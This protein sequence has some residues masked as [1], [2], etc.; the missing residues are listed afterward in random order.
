MT[1]R[2]RKVRKLEIKFSKRRGSCGRPERFFSEEDKEAIRK[3]H[4]DLSVNH[5]ERIKIIGQMIGMKSERTIRKI[6]KRHQIIENPDTMVSEEYKEAKERKFKK[7]GKRFFVTWAQNNTPVHKQFLDNIKAYSKKIGAEIHVVLG[8]YKNP[9]SIWNH[10]NQADEFWDPSVLPYK[11][12]N[13][14]DIHKHFSILSDIKIQPTAAMPMSGLEG[15]SGS[16]SCVVGFP[17]VHLKVIPAL[18]G[19]RPKIMLTTGAVTEK[20][21]TD[22]KSGKKSEFHHTYGFCIVEIKNNEDF[23][24]RQVTAMEDGS[25]CDLGYIVDK[26]A[27]KKVDGISAAV[28]GDCH[29]GDHD[30]IVNKMQKG[31]LDKLKPK[32]TILHDVFNG[33]SVNPHE[34][35]DPIKQ[36]Q[37]HVDGTNRVTHEINEMLSWIDSMKKYNLVITSANHNDFL[38][39][40]IR[41]ADWKK[42]IANAA[43]Y[44]EYTNVLLSGKA[45]NGIIDYVIRKRFGS[46]VKT[47]GRNESFSVNGWELANHGDVGANGSRGGIGQYKRLTTKMI[48]GHS[49]T[50]AREDGVLYV[51]T[52]TKLR[53]GYNIG[54]SSWLNADVIVHKN[55]KA[56]HI[57]YFNGQFTTLKF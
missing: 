26:G 1:K 54:A 11:D 8:R 45:P 43:E 14:H 37:R 4:G 7:S 20:N 41:K 12:A 38:D 27:V 22:S 48:C 17:K 36:Y 31:W 19:Y 3:V 15:V 25:F 57:I 21:Y 39:R 34:A 6:L 40:W 46:V 18:E 33:H 47:L 53:V 13:R 2:S 55:G 49:H 35:D 16:R 9:T 50:P 56:Q 24:V 32:H 52:S 5:G 51:G 42:N 29:V 28:L 30:P 10:N 44:L 23:F